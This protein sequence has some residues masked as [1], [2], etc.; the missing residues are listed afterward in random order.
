MV[1]YSRR[2]HESN[3]LALAASVGVLHLPYRVIAAL[4]LALQLGLVF[5]STRSQRGSCTTARG[6]LQSDD[7]RYSALHYRLAAATATLQTHYRNF[8]NYS[9]T[10]GTLQHGACTT[11]RRL[12]TAWAES[13]VGRVVFTTHSYRAVALYSVPTGTRL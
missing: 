9:Y 3:Y 7:Y 10:T 8:G 6:T 12:T 11:A 13:V 1:A 4:Q 2:Y 5:R